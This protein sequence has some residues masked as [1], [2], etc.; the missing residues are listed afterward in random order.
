MGPLLSG[1]LSKPF[2]IR[3]SPYK[4]ATIQRRRFMGKGRRIAVTAIL[5][6]ILCP[7]IFLA[8]V[9]A[10]AKAPAPI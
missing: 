4:D 1:S 2:M 10:V 8:P 9:K 3:W 7:I 5:V 6:V